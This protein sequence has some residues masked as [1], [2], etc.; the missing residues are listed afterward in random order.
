MIVSR[1]FF[2]S[3]LCSCILGA[4]TSSE[5][6]PEALLNIVLVDAPPS[7]DSVFVEILGVEVSINAVGRETESQSIFI[8]YDLGDKQ[9]KVSDLVAGEVLLL[10]RGVLPPGRLIG[11]KMILGT[12]HFL[13]QDEDRFAIPIA[14]DFS[15]EVPI[16][17]LFDLEAGL[18][19][20]VILDF[21]LEQ[22]I[23]TIQSDPLTL[24]LT[25]QVDAVLPGTFGEIQG[26]LGPT[27][28]KPSILA[29]GS[30]GSSSTHTNSSGS[31]VMRLSPGTY[32]LY[33]DPKDD[34]YLTDTLRN[35]EVI[36]GES[37]S[38]EPIT[39]N[40]APVDDE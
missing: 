19:Y 28:I 8:P 17:I 32:D 18:S 4:C 15:D 30:S 27:T 14:S 35:V 13:W 3:I 39:F 24:A 38:L 34:R 31:F 9:I 33:L 16:P 6:R 5:N 20:D 26:R 10:G 12:R 25:P 37:L 2:I 7:Y 1:F 29:V 11:M 21:D 23:Q 40:L 22:S 36:L